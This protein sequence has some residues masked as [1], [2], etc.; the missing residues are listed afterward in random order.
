MTW[1]DHGVHSYCTVVWNSHPQ[2]PSKG[3]LI[4]KTY[5][6][7]CM[8]AGH[9]I[10][11]PGNICGPPNLVHVQMRSHRT[12]RFSKARGEESK[13][14]HGQALEPV[15]HTWPIE[16]TSENLWA[17]LALAFDRIC[18]QASKCRP[19]S[20]K[21]FSIQMVNAQQNLRGHIQGSI[22]HIHCLVALWIFVLV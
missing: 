10:W 16:Y 9:N 14:V 21:T 20:N 8:S 17:I 1:M 11:P 18:L 2:S 6:S 13:V 3:P 12:G 22:L 5:E 7:S 15:P 19:S 4:L